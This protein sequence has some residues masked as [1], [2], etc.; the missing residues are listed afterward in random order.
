MK[1]IFV[2]LRIY[3]QCL[4][5]TGRGLGKN[6]WTLLLPVGLR[7]V[8]EQLEALL[9]TAIGPLM[10]G[11]V[12]GLIMAAVASCYLYFLGGVVARSRVSLKEFSQSIRTYFWSVTNVMFVLWI[13]SLISGTLLQ[14]LPQGGLLKGLMWLAILLLCNA[15]PEVIYIRGTYGGLL[16]LQ[17]S[18]QFLQDNWIEWAFP[19]LVW[20]ALLA[21]T[22]YGPMP[23]PTWAS[24]V[25]FG[26]VFH[27]GMVYRGHLF[28]ALDGSNHRQRMFRYH[29]GR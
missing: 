1:V 23:I 16:T 2:Y 28:Q 17:R 4:R 5:E 29:G 14:S 27:V 22:L 13:A 11:F 10:G 7:L 20:L 3:A 6:A 9:V 8:F 18:L 19:N 25:L 21:A 24:G 26:A 12:I 15:T